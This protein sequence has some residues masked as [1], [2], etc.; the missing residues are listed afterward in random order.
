MKRRGVILEEEA[1]RGGGKKR[2][3]KKVDLGAMRF[4]S[5]PTSYYKHCHCGTII[6]SS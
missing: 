1:G 6:E 4:N 5:C 3:R 2:I